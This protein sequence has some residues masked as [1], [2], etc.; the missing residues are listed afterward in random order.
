MAGEEHDVAHAEQQAL[1]A[2]CTRC[3]AG[4][5]LTLAGPFPG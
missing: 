1:T 4:V 2:N 5:P 3:G